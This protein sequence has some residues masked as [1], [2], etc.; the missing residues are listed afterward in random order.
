MALVLASVP[1]A[2]QLFAGETLKYEF[3]WNGIAAA[4]VLVKIRPGNCDE[5]CL[6]GYIEGNG[7]K[8]LDMFWRVRDRF[9][10]TVSSKDYSPRQY[11]FLQRE[12]GFKLDTRIWLD[13][14]ANLLKSRR[15]RVDKNKDY[16][17]KQAPAEGMYDPLGAILYMRSRPL[18]VGDKETVNVFDG[19]RRHV[20][21]WTV[22]GKE[23]VSIK[24]G[25]FDAIKIFPR[26]IKSSTRDDESKVEKVKKVTIWVEDKPA[27][28]VLKI[29]SEAFVGHI[30]A[31]LAGR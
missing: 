7:R 9:E 16:T 21:E 28:T 12:G 26:I 18:N 11:A 2:A 27:H 22:L 17:D 15:Y 14:S 10:F 6:A 24:L 25:V 19:K 3:G 30:Y 13:K 20:L 4:D 8:Y 29:E 5:P 23:R 1:A 31:E